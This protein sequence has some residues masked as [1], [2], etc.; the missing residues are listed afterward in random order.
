MSLLDHL[1]I[2]TAPKLGCIKLGEKT[3]IRRLA[4]CGHEVGDSSI[5]P[6]GPR[7]KNDLPS[8]RALLGA[9]QTRREK[10]LPH[11]GHTAPISC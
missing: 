11:R 10:E 4:Q 1:K 9:P 8:S 3:G 7:W 6:L 5:H 2:I